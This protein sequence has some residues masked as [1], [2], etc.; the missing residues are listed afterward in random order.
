[1]IKFRYEGNVAFVNLAPSA[2][3]SSSFIHVSYSMLHFAHRCGRD[4][5]DRGEI[6]GVK[7]GS[8]GWKTRE[9]L[10]MRLEIRVVMGWRDLV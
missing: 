1:M 6:G 9:A 7:R 8:G 3:I 4:R 10:Q 5:R 2:M